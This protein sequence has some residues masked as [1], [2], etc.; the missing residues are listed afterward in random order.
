MDLKDLNKSQLILLV[1]LVSFV[2]SI[3]TGITTVTLMQQAPSSVTVPINRVIK[4]TVEKIVP[5]TSN[6]VQTVVVKEEDLIVDAI[7]K[8]ESSV[9]SFTREIWDADNKLAEIN[10]GRGFVIS[11]DGTVVADNTLVYK[12]GGNYFVKNNSGKFKVDSI[13]ELENGISFVKIGSPLDENNKLSFSLPTFGNL[14]KMKIGQKI[15]VLGNTITSF[16]YEGNSNLES[17]VS[18][19]NGG[20]LVFNLDGEVLGIALSGEVNTFLSIDS[21]LESFNKKVPAIETKTP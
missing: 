16:I 14:E 10:A 2:T 6:T 19:A 5:A 17:T 1:L 9:F 3:A 4:Q 7:S 11:S 21:I 13:T 12:N 15:L 18:K 8:N 20:S